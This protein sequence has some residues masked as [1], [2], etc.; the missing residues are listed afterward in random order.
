MRIIKRLY[1]F[2]LRSFL[3]LLAMTFLIVLFIV[4]MQFLWK[5]IDDLVGKGLSASVI[6]ELFFY[7]ALKMVPMAL[8]L[9][10]LLASLMTF[11]NLGEKFE[12]TAMKASGISLVRVMKPLIVLMVCISVGAFFFQNEVLPKVQVKMWTLF[13][14]IRQKSPELEIPEGVFYDQIPGYNMFVGSKDRET[15]MLHNMM[16]YDVSHGGDNS[17]ILLADSGRLAFTADNRYL[18]LHLYKGEQFEN[19]R[20]QKALDRNVPFRRESFADK[21]VLI[22]FDANFNR[23]DEDNMRNQFVGKNMKELNIAIDSISHR[24]DSIGEI[25]AHDLNYTAF[26]ML[27][28]SPSGRRGTQSGGMHRPDVAATAASPA[29]GARSGEEEN[30]DGELM[31]PPLD[32][33][34]LLLSVG[35][36]ERRQIFESALDMSKRSVSDYQFKSM[37][38]SEEKR[39]LRNHQIE[40]IKKFTLSVACLIFFFIGAPLGAII[41]K[42]GLGTPLVISVLLF[43]FYYIVDTAGWKMAKEGHWAVWMGMWLSTFVLAPLGIFVT[44]KAMNDSAVFDAD[45]Y[46]AFFRKLFGT[47]VDRKVTYK[48]VIINDISESEAIA[49]LTSLANDSK[50]FCED[51]AKPQ[52]YVQYWK[53]GYDISRISRIS[54]DLEEDVEYLTDCR[55]PMAVNK[56]MDYPVIR[57]LW[58]YC[59]GGKKWMSIAGMVL[60]PIGIVVYLIGLRAQHNLK[61]E[62]RKV[63]EVSRNICDLLDVAPA[64]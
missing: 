35:D 39:N 58:V 11:G 25:Y 50:A 14:S 53:H 44:Y 51:Y 4:L 48:E 49:K 22:P 55:N 9:A 46:K 32:M 56:L 54:N 2:V 34:S 6:G 18:Y 12:L 40:L 42:G 63:A 36:G 62:L 31:L 27:N 19:L 10:I 64:S 38:I 8:P 41:R 33:D 23:M 57:T 3:P 1:V 17:T 15:G 43:L 29:A 30:A 59:P 20:E 61:G 5:Y 52:S 21:E 16:I 13:F 60:F 37:M 7:A 26:P 28:E 45:R 47:R 24:M